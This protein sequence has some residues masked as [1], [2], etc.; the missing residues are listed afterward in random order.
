MAINGALK[1]LV[2]KVVSE[3]KNNGAGILNT[4]EK[5]IGWKVSPGSFYPLMQEL[6]NLKF[7]KFGKES[8]VKYY[9]I[10]PKGKLFLKQIDKKKRDISK[11]VEEGM[12][13]LKEFEG[14]K[15]IN[16]MNCNLDQ[17]MVKFILLEEEIFSFNEA[18]NQTNIKEHRKKV[19]RIFN[20]A[21]KDLRKL[22]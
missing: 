10:A 19:Q 3:K 8:T 15:F 17:N 11:K 13:F 6:V 12:K 5:R 22:K 21:T 9:S 1:F 7:V 4:I 2:L 16:K 14:E 20:K 18:L